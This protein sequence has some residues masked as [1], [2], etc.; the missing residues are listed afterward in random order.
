MEI[1]LEGFEKRAKEVSDYFTFLRE[2]EQQEVKLI[3]DGNISKIDTELAKTLKATGYL[4]LYNLVESTLRDAIESI[5]DEIQTRN[6]SFDNLK[7][8]FKK[9]IWKNI[10]KRNV[11]QLTTK[12][13]ILS[14]HI[15]RESFD[16]N[17]LFSG[18]VDARK[19]K[20]IAMIYG[21]S[22][23]TDSKTTKDGIDLLSIKKNR[24]DLAHGILPFSEV[25][26]GATAENLLEISDRVIKYLRQIL[27][28]INEY[29]E[30]EEYLDQT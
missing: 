8:E 19:I 22:T 12:I 6:I 15:I 9:M 13:T 2:L 23:I 24:N 28:N 10:K 20:K 30:R 26:E 17:D 5:F 14:Q 18:N 16:P 7:I 1:I 27:E 25:G 29:L 4:L 11:D 21:F 3:K